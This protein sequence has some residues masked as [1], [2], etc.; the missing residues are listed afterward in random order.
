M[1][2]VPARWRP[3]RVRN[4]ISC[5]V[6]V[7]NSSI[8]LGQAYF[9]GRSERQAARAITPPWPRVDGLLRHSCASL[10]LDHG[11]DLIII[12]ELLGH[13]HISITADTYARP[14]SPPARRHRT[15]GQR[16]RRPP[17]T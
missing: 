4:V 2:S 10:L 6:E 15:H 7:T 5:S 14:A 13:A 17:E 3:S 16:P 1:T 12:K 11:V 9:R 8:R